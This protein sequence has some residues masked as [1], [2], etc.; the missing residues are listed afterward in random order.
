[1]TQLQMSA[2]AYHRI[3][4][5]ARTIADQAGSESIRPAHVAQVIHASAGRGSSPDSGAVAHLTAKAEPCANPR[6]FPGTFFTPALAKDVK[7]AMF[8]V[9]G[10][11]CR[12]RGDVLE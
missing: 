1:V 8:C 3:L 2:R 4:K 5:L 10:P 12:P 6:N 11:D 9:S 7:G